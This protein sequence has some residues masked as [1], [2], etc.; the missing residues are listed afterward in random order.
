MPIIGRA[1]RS[2]QFS[3]LIAL[4]SPGLSSFFPFAFLPPYPFPI[5]THSHSHSPERLPCG[6]YLYLIVFT[7]NTKL[8]STNELEE[9]VLYG[10]DTSTVRGARRGARVGFV[11][12]VQGRKGCLVALVAVIYWA[13]GLTGSS[14]RA[15]ILRSAIRR[16]FYWTAHY[17]GSL[18]LT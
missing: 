8:K 13:A 18:K 6:L 3:I 1:M 16:R 5:P 10:T 17:G 7:I 9:T 14:P 12:V 2:S 11:R 15:F 4:P